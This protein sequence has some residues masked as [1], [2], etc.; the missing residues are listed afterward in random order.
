MTK[1]EMMPEEQALRVDIA[2]AF[3]W[4]QRWEMDDLAGG[5]LVARLPGQ[6]DWMLTNIQGMYFDEIKASDL[7]RVSFDN[8]VLDGS[9]LR[10]NYGAVNPAA[11]LFNARPD[12]NA[13]VH[14][15]CEPVMAMLAL[16]CGILPISAPAFMFQEGVCLYRDGLSL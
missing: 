2:A 14:V 5:G 3:R 15:H 6:T 7:I 10:S 4:L 12:V 11:K 13:V 1:I 8:E 16:K 9:N